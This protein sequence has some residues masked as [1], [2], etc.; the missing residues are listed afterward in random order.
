ML[1]QVDGDQVAI[2]EGGDGAT[3]RRFG[4]DVA[5]AGAACAAGEAAIGD[6]RDLL[7]E[8]H[9]HDIGGGGQHLLHA[10]TAAWPLV[11]NDH[12]IAL[13]DMPVEN[14][15]ARLLLRIVDARPAFSIVLSRWR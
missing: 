5:D 1:D 14:A 8:A 9:T 3:C 6:E 10:G 11:A 13:F 7:T 15:R 4:R 2:D 12:H